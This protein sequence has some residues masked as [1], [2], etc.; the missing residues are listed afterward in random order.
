MRKAIVA[1]CI[2]AVA[3]A[4][5]PA[6]AATVPVNV[7]NNNFDP[8]SRLAAP[9]DTVSFT[10][11][12]GQHTITAFEGATFDSGIR[13]SGYQMTVPFS[14]TRIRYR[15]TLHSQ[16]SQG[17]QCSG[18]CGVIEQQTSDLTPPSVVITDPRSREVVIPQ[19][20]L[21]TVQ[22][23]VVIAGDAT[24]N[25]RLLAVQVRIYDT[26]GMPK[27]WVASCPGCGSA[28]S[29]FEVRADLLP[30][31]YVAEPIAIDVS[32]NLR[33]GERVAFFVV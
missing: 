11:L 13:S 22:R 21:A 20:Q 3:I 29:R 10:W 24:D 31:S 14:G 26:L 16:L 27:L 2:G 23:L 28:V 33:T 15:C 12:E 7:R 5:A 8:T 17:T 6:H 1:A 18:M 32:G 9:G 19:P 4:A 25:D 30:G